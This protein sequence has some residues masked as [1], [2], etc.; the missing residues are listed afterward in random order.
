M[1]YKSSL[2][3]MAI[4]LAPLKLLTWVA[5]FKLKGIAEL[6]ALNFDIEERKFYIQVQLFGEPEAIEVWIEDFAIINEEEAYHFVVQKAESNKP[7]LNNLLSL[8]T[9]KAWKIPVI[10]QMAAH[11]ELIAELLAAP[12][13]EPKEDQ[14]D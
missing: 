10:P 9:G 2:V 8:I 12:K 1:S 11:L 6:A 4:K 13:V 14:L 7:W 3:K 5:N